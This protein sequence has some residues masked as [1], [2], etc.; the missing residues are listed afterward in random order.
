MQEPD[1]DGKPKLWQ[2]TGNGEADGFRTEALNKS[3]ERRSILLLILI[4]RL[5]SSRE[6][7]EMGD[8]SNETET[9][10]G[11]EAERVVVLADAL[12]MDITSECGGR[13]YSGFKM[14]QPHSS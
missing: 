6:R 13:C 7:V 5:T 1:K 2:K 11:E 8:G 10:T 9:E 3:R 12:F 4:Y 14:Q